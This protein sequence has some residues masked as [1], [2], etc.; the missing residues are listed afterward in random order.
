MIEHVLERLPI[1]TREPW[2]RAF[3]AAPWM[4]LL[5]VVAIVAGA[6]LQHGVFVVIR[7]A[8]DHDG[9]LGT[10][11]FVVGM[12]PLAI[13]W[14]LLILVPIWVLVT[15]PAALTRDLPGPAISGLPVDSGRLWRLRAWCFL[16]SLLGVATLLG[17][18]HSF[19]IGERPV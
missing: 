5:C 11:A 12:V 2:A 1:R 9:I 18:L 16:W 19:G 6:W 7:L 13:A 3:A 4:A 10:M 14:F 15:L 8:E 17:T